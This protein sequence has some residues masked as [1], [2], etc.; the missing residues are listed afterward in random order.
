MIAN[1]QNPIIFCLRKSKSDIK[2]EFWENKKQNR[3]TMRFCCYMWY[4]CQIDLPLVGKNYTKLFV[5]EYMR[6]FGDNY[7][8]VDKSTRGKAK[9]R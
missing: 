6:C 7:F 3:I 4:Q 1:V 8:L 5:R 2:R 9:K